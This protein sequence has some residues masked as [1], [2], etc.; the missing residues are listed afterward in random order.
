MGE[1]RRAREPP[2]QHA[3][4]MLWAG[5]LAGE[6]FA[7]KC[8][9]GAAFHPRPVGFKKVIARPIW[10][11]VKNSCPKWNPGKWK[12]GVNLWSPDGLIVTHIHI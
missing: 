1:V 6:V 10:L 12:H 11:W 7:A 3:V 8:A 4:T 5:H 2:R 9:A